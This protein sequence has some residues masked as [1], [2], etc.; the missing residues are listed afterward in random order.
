MVNVQEFKQA[1]RSNRVKFTFTKVDGTERIAIGTTQKET[2]DCFG[3]M[4]NGSGKE[5]VG[6]VAYY[7]LE[8]EGWR[9]CREDSIISFEIFEG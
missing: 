7:D 1:L 9:S 3:V 6:V 5:K 4:P 8:K 2:L